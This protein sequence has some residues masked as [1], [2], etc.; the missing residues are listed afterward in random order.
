MWSYP[1]WRICPFRNRT[2]LTNEDTGTRFNDRANALLNISQILCLC[3]KQ[4][5]VLLGTPNVR[6]FWK[7]STLFEPFT[8][9]TCRCWGISTMFI[10]SR[11]FTRY[12]AF[13]TLNSLSGEFPL[14]TSSQMN[15][16]L[17]LFTGPLNSLG[18]IL[19]PRQANIGRYR[20]GGYAVRA[21]LTKSP[22]SIALP[23]DLAK[24][25]KYNNA[26]L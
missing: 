26:R 13:C 5:N 6:A 23:L 17:F 24:F 22:G 21:S 10:T 15:R 18:G 1:R 8:G 11:Y 19:Q 20:V 16:I 14:K 9:D 2:S 25:L 4:L 12:A 3:W 7:A